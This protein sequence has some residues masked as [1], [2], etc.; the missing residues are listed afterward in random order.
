MKI[1]SIIRLV[2]KSLNLLKLFSRIYCKVYIARDNV[3]ISFDTSVL[4]TLIWPAPSRFTLKQF[5]LV[6]KKTYIELKI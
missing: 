6:V 5:S 2:S 4:N 1:Y 3:I